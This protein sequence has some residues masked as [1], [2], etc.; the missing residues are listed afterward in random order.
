MCL[1]RKRLLS[2]KKK[3][4]Q[5]TGAF[6]EK[7][8]KNPSLQH[9]NH[10]FPSALTQH[11]HTSTYTE[12]KLVKVFHRQCTTLQNRRI[13][14]LAPCFLA[15]LQIPLTGFWSLLH[16]TTPFIY[17]LTKCTLLAPCV[18]SKPE[19]RRTSMQ[20][21]PQSWLPQLPAFKLHRV[22]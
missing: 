4:T 10:T 19:H 1:L 9:T 20:A 14:S 8:K 18:L 22:Q 2:Q 15:P 16:P 12:V 21:A 3:V 7:R 13:I 6:L 11:T 5:K 17:C